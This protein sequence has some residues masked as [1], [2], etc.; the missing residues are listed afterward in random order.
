MP[1]GGCSL[2][3]SGLGIAERRRKKRLSR[4]SVGQRDEDV[5]NQPEASSTTP[6]PVPAAIDDKEEDTEGQQQQGCQQQQ[7][8]P[9]AAA[10]SKLAARYSGIP[11]PRTTHSGSPR[12]VARVPTIGSRVGL[13]GGR[14]KRG[15]WGR[16]MPSIIG[17]QRPKISELLLEA[18]AEVECATRN[19]AVLS[20]L[21]DAKKRG[22]L[23]VIDFIVGKWKQAGLA[24]A[25]LAW[26]LNHVAELKER[27]QVESDNM[28]WM[29]SLKDR[30]AALQQAAQD[31]LVT[32]PRL[33]TKQERE[34][35]ER[36]EE[37]EPTLPQM[38]AT[39]T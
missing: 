20:A 37:Q 10:P 34:E 33:E 16:N 28:I 18:S 36:H 2:R 7:R 8:T 9:G 11:T 3:P 1:P 22:V 38:D 31:F 14:G 29:N 32:I 17:R 15:P 35:R 27:V 30:D 6:T 5:E 39:L 19:E 13:R 26:K 21:D 23:G 4:R 24:M 25:V 12:A